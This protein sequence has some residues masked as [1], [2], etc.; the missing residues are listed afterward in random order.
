MEYHRDFEI[1][2]HAKQIAVEL[3]MPFDLTRI[4]CMRSF[5][6]TSRGTLARC[7][8]VPKVVQKALNM[9][10]HYVIE[11]LSENFDKLNDVEKTKTIIHELM[12]IPKSMGGGFRQHDFVCAKNVDVMYK[13]LKLRRADN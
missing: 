1:E 8:T 10:G 5:G 7:H 2:K 9:E 12:H 3:G 13:R 11:F 4:V 6:S